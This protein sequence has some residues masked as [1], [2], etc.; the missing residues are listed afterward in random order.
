MDCVNISL[1]RGAEEEK[2]ELRGR[3]TLTRLIKRQL[4]INNPGFLKEVLQYETGFLVCAAIGVLFII[5]VPLVGLFFCCCRCCEH[6][7]G[8]LYQKQT[9]HT[10]CRR[11]AFFVSVL[12]VTTILLAGD[13]CAYINNQR[14][15]QTVGRGFL[16]LNSTMHNLHIYLE[17][18]P[19]EIDMIINTSSVPLNQANNSLLNI[20][21]NLGNKIKTQLGGQANK[22]LDAVDHLLR[23][24]GTVEQ[25]LK[26]VNKSGSHLQILQKELDR[27]LTI[28]GNNINKT[29]DDCGVPCRNV[30]VPNLK[31]G[32]NLSMVPDVSH[33]LQLIKNLTR[34]D[35]NGTL[36]EARKILENIPE[37]VSDQTKTAVSDAQEKLHY[38]KQQIDDIRGNFSMLN[39][40]K[41]IS[42]LMNDI[43]R[44]A[45]TYEPEIVTYDGYRWIVGVVLCC[46]VLLIIVLNVFGLL[47][48]ALGLDPQEM[49]TQRSCLSNSGGLFLMASVGFCFIF[50]WLLMLLVLVT[51]LIGGNTYTLVCRPWANGRLLEFLETPDLFPELNVSKLMQ[52]NVPDVTLSSMYKSCEN[53]ASLW[54]TLHLNE[55]I[56]L[57]EILNISKYTDDIDSAL[58]KIN[59]SVGST[60]FLKDDQ[61]HLMQDLG[62]KNGLLKLDF[63][64]AL[65]QINQNMTNQDLFALAAKLDTLATQSHSPN[66][67][68]KLRNQ[69]A[70]AR[71]IQEWMNDNF[72]PEI[73]VLNS[74]IR[75]L[76][77]SLPQ[78]PDLVNS[79]LLEVEAA[80]EFMRKKTGEIIKNAT[81]TFVNSVL[82]YFELYMD[83]VKSNI[84]EKVG[85]CG[86]AAWTVDSMNTIFCDYIVDS[87]NAFWFSLGWCTVFLLPNI[88]LAVKLAKFY[89]RMYMDDFYVDDATETME[90]SRQHMFKMP[91]AE[92]K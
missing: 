29:L 86:P 1:V 21:S 20:G 23:V 57:D 15:S 56:S 50:A 49:P 52:L 13:I 77:K 67:S 73:H 85:C 53:N 72:P 47:F 48:G 2:P 41:N 46:L 3:D 71:K 22:A 90:L 27:N 14:I 18:I 37:K 64:D 63:A 16:T 55:A 33:P 12:A 79:T 89:R 24:V 17:S 59:V 44:K 39:F 40:L 11:K 78:I 74:S 92:L 19:Q 76:Q 66:I 10:G 4:D 30:S 91:R 31:S 5:L 9:K 8:F 6:C 80:Q 87:L 51:F 43:I 36:T 82:S 69:A 7:G 34:S 65:A 42:D 60:D 62:K 38:V 58:N 25:E 88:I 28:L 32:A 70:E 68:A 81:M 61:K 45:T 83:W 54:N 26:E 35:P 84:K 75:S